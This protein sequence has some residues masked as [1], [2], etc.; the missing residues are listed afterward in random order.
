MYYVFCVVITFWMEIYIP[1]AE[2]PVRSVQ[3]SQALP[4][5]PIVSSY[6]SFFPSDANVA[7]IWVDILRLVSAYLPPTRSKKKP[8]RPK[9]N[10]FVWQALYHTYVFQAGNIQSYREL[11]GLYFGKNA[12]ASLFAIA[13]LLFFASG[14]YFAIPYI[15]VSY[16]EL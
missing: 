7:E 13:K 14:S 3:P 9:L 1:A 15:S 11:Q 16:S 4:S 5:Y 10:V 8:G 12:I 6:L 2:S